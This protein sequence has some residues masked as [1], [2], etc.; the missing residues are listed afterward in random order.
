MAVFVCSVYLGKRWHQD[1]LWDKTSRWMQCGTLD[2]VLLGN[3]GSSHSCRC[4]FDMWYCTYLNIVAHQIHSFMTVV[5]HGGCGLFQQDNAPTRQTLFWN[6][7]KNTM[8]SSTCC[9]DLQIPQISNQLWD[10]LDQQQVRSTAA[11][12]CN[13]QDLKDL[14]CNI[15]VPERTPSVL[16]SSCLDGSIQQHSRQAVIMFW[17]IDVNISIFDQ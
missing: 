5:F 4:K 7:L 2:D 12:P 3:P 13:L 16:Q 14:L 15:L 17:L 11:S 6:D 9:P 1:A 8:R 10:V